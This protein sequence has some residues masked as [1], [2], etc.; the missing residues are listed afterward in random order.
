MPCL[1]RW[2]LGSHR[3]EPQPIEAKRR[4]LPLLRPEK[5]VMEN[6]GPY[7]GRVEL[8]FSK[9][10]DIFLITGKTGAGKTTIFDAICFA[11]YGKVPGSRGDHTARLCSDHAA[12]GS[13]SFVSLEFLM[14][15]KR[16]RAERS[17][18]QERKKKRGEGTVTIE[19]TLALYE[20]AGDKKVNL[21]SKKSEGDSRLK[22]I[23]GLDAEEFFKVV[24]LPQGEFAEFLKQ[25]TSERQKVLGKLF[26][27]ENAVKVKELA[28]KKAAGAE[29]QVEGAARILA[30]I[31]KRVNAE[32]YE[33][34]HA[35]ASALF[36]KAA[37]KGR[38]LEEEE[39]LLTR[40]LA[41]R[42]NE[43]DAEEH[44][45]ESRGLLEETAKAEPSVNE[46]NAALSRSRAARP[47]EQYLRGME[48]AALAVKAAEAALAGAD[49]ERNAAEKIAEEAEKLNREVPALEKETLALREK[50]PAL[51]EML[52]DEKNLKA[53]EG[54]LQRL[55]ARTEKLASNGKLL[56]DE[57]KK[58]ETLIEE[59]ETIAAELPE[60]EDQLEL[61]KFIKDIFVQFRTYRER[62]D[63][64]EKE[65]SL[66]DK[67]IKDLE[68]R[69][70]EYE[71]IIPVLEAEV[72]RLK[73]EKTRKEQADMAAHLSA[74]LEPG[75]PCPVC[76]SAEHP[77]PALREEA[78]FGFDE[79]IKAQEAALL[80]AEKNRSAVREKLEAKKREE[81]K[82]RDS[83]KLLETEIRQ[84]RQ[85]ALR[86]PLGTFSAERFS[87]RQEILPL[88]EN[89]A[90][91]PSKEG[92]DKLIKAEV[93]TLNE[94]LDRQKNSRDAQGRKKELY[95]RRTEKRDEL[96]ET[97]KN[98][99]A[100]DEQKKNLVQRIA[101]GREKHRTL[102]VSAAFPGQTFTSAA[103]A[104]ASLNS[105]IAEKENF[106]AR[107]RGER[108]QAILRLS[109]AKAAWEGALR[110]HGDSAAR[111]KDA[112][113]ALETALSGTDFSG[114]AE[115]E[116][117]L[118]EPGS[119]EG[120][121]KEIRFWREK[122]AGLDTQ[123]AEQEKQ[124]K[125]I[126][127]ELAGLAARPPL[128]E[129]TEERLGSLKRERAAAEEE[130]TRAFAALNSLEKDLDALHDAQKRHD[131]LAAEARKYRVLSD[132]LSGKN[133]R[134]L[135]FDSWLLANYLEEA[136]AYATKRLEKMSDFR[137]SLLLDS[138]RQQGRGYAGLDLMVFDAHT[139]KSRP[140]ATLSGGESFM[141]SI[142]LALGL[143]D[144]IQNR[145]GGAKLDAV[146]IDEGF[147]SL[148]EA[149]LDK[150]LMILDEL[151]DSRMV[152]LISH[153]GELRSRIPCQVE[154]VK[155]DSGSKI[156]MPI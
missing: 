11:L 80:D 53:L 15:Q 107:C 31:G 65:K 74:L 122:R 144:S 143:S 148:D 3:H 139:G 98:L 89:N 153:V 43:R 19:E 44:L 69:A 87:A 51:A 154:I 13:G 132:D 93:A 104:L 17:P 20:I 57:L 21:V 130:K 45:A 41:V 46:K 120:L 12:E 75:K 33:A 100:F 140:C 55:Q 146:F 136:A 118:L 92:I 96:G 6:F 145:S 18:R 40:L 7:S 109:G 88:L 125:A 37:E 86:D 26:P 129:E 106:I 111:L 2:K 68:H 115:A 152:G 101:E 59:N 117:A 71:E 50:R 78:P 102:L 48:N 119:E 28:R 4:G 56:L 138:G 14:G 5:L 77:C 35:E 61:S 8:D 63:A 124:V 121:E 79:R 52:E 99:A 22:E 66:A 131:A 83:C 91:V 137:Y 47:L 114:P 49:E 82:V 70:G 126:R 85:S 150:A 81:L 133:L 112:R 76:G 142:S 113:T 29:A 73:V 16:Y 149:S 24:L 10:E 39:A 147:G 95:L 36:G 90:P 135:P 72:Q 108:E 38:S 1:P 105:V 27:V 60:L 23:T 30:D 123:I 34:A 151:R 94:I 116:K 141:A 127:R 9:L 42:R 110:N 58:Q 156:K 103:N 62:V 25:N 128:L 67:E 64:L 84:T 32:T 97:E 54:E 155:T 134:K